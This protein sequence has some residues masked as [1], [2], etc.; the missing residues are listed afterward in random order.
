MTDLTNPSP[1]AGRGDVFRISRSTPEST[2]GLTVAAVVVLALVTLP[3]W[4]SDG[5]LQTPLVVILVYL[6]LAQMWNLLAG[7]AGLVSIGQQMFVGIGIYSLLTLAEDWGIDPFL[8]VGLAGLVAAVLSVPVALFAFRLKGGYFAI[9]TWVIAEVFR[10]L[11]VD[12]QSLG[13]G[14]VRSLT[15]ASLGGYSRQAREDITYWLAVALA[16]GA[17]AIVV[18]ALRSRL[19]LGLRA[20]RDNEAGARGL[21]VDVTR[22]KLVV[23]VV[24][25]FWTGA[26]GA[27]I[28]LNSPSTRADSA[29]SV[30]RWTALVIFI[31][32]IGGVGSTTGPIIGV[33]VFWAIDEQLT[34][35]ETWRFIILGLIAAAMAVLAPKGLYGLLQRWRPVQ[36]FP[37]RRRLVRTREDE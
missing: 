30:L 22:T 8:S 31:A 9:G 28:L 14:N 11:V 12:N 34:D 5:S 13:G 1:A 29:F 7:F 4:D 25:A 2:G 19:G 6:S 32:V 10:L 20:V 24:A 37:V 26:T 17:T 21:G 33:L 36:F 23:W 16:V 18:F 15:R 35:A 27:V 3:W